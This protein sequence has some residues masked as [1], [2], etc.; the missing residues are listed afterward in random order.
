MEEE[1]SP[2]GGGCL[3]LGQ[4]VQ[5]ECPTPPLL[6]VWRLARLQ[7]PPDQGGLVAGV[8]VLT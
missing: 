1:F 4:S 6:L 5:K 3:R 7:P 8:L 2:K